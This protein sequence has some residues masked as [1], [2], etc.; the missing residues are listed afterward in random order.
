MLIFIFCVIISAEIGE[1]KLKYYFK[2]DY[3]RYAHPENSP[4][5]V[6]EFTKKDLEIAEKNTELIKYNKELFETAVYESDNT[7]EEA[8][9]GTIILFPEIPS[10][11]LLVME[12]FIKNVFADV[13]SELGEEYNEASDPTIFWETGINGKHFGGKTLNYKT[14]E[15]FGINSPSI[16]I[17]GCK[18]ST[19]DYLI[20]VAVDKMYLESAKHDRK[21][22]GTDIRIGFD[23]YKTFLVYSVGSK[24]FYEFGTHENQLYHKP[25]RAVGGSGN[26]PTIYEFLMTGVNPLND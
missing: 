11:E 4:R 18:D 10:N 23:R 21:A 22:K 3:F 6:G 5:T 17:A 20:E 15:T 8:Q 9:I 24:R 12:D 26:T 25:Q 14:K 2:S 1:Q 16:Y 19:A 13:E 7:I